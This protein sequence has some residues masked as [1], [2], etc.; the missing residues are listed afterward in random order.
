MQITTFDFH[1]TVAH[2]D[3]WFDLEIRELPASVLVE[4]CG[5]A[6]DATLKRATVVYRELRRSIMDTGIEKDAQSS[7]EHVFEIMGL[8]IEPTAIAGATERLMRE[9]LTHLSPVPGAVESITALIDAGVPVGIIS[10]AVYHPFLEWALAEFE[11]LDRLAFVATSASIGYYK[12]DVRIYRHAYQLADATIELGVHVGDSPRW[13][14]VTAQ[15]AGLG[16]VLYAP[17]EVIGSKG[18]EAGTPDL[19]LTSL[20]DADIPIRGLL[21]DRMAARPQ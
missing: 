1:N 14:V 9:A 15:L 6:D 12:S 3:Q 19:V 18:H 7:L 17:E 4:L 20:I 13:D 8:K 21:K 10:S 16:T 2:C 11:L 5:T